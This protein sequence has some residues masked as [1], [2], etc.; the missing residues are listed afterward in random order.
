M[1]Y[2]CYKVNLDMLIYWFFRLYKTK[3]ATINPKN[4]DDKFLQYVV[5]VAL[6]YGETESH[7][8]RISNIKPFINIYKW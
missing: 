2:K 7:L 8:E 3:L 6:N 5:M 1:Y 4:K